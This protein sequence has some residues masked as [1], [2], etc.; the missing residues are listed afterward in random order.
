MPV[1]E[2][3]VGLGSNLGDREAHL[4]RA[5]EGLR[6]AGEVVAVSSL[7]ETAP[8]GVEGDQPP[9][10]NAVVVLQTPLAPRLLLEHLLELEVV[11]GR[12][13]LR[14]LE[15]RTLDL[16]LLLHGNAQVADDDLILPHPRLTER[17]FVL[18]PLAEVRPD[19]VLPDGRQI[20]AALGALSDQEVRVFGPL[21]G[22]A[23]APR[24]LDRAGV[25]ELRTRHIAAKRR[26]P[27]CVGAVLVA[28]LLL[29]AACSTDAAV[30]TAVSTATLPAP[31]VVTA[32]P[33]VGASDPIA[34]EFFALP[35]L[36]DCGVEELMKVEGVEAGHDLEGRDCLLTAFDAGVDA[37]FTSTRLTVNGDPVVTHYRTHDGVLD[38]FVDGTADP[39]GEPRWYAFT[40]DRVDLF[41]DPG[42]ARLFTPVGCVDYAL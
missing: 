24:P 34:A 13:R 37:Q 39:L 3:I 27:G 18:E 32:S 33:P 41:G 4:R 10:L 6:L 9:Y 28:V 38:L 11:A 42:G 7:Y 17:R 30:P 1:A 36:A 5:V 23:A 21:G 12:H 14:R 19:L 29:A 40:C 22:V 26:R 8:L 35:D 20:G 15:P 31:T 16:D 2:A 25:R